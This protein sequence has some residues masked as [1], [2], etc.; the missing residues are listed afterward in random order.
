MNDTP[1]QRDTV[2]DQS[3]PIHTEIPSTFA[4]RDGLARKLA[5][6]VQKRFTIRPAPGPRQAHLRRSSGFSSS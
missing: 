1:R 5:S 4:E 6:A 3:A 2:S